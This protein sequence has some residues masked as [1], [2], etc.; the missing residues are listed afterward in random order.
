MPPFQRVDAIIPPMLTLETFPWPPR[1]EP[2]KTSEIF[3]DDWA[4]SADRSARHSGKAAQTTNTSEVS[5]EQAIAAAARELVQ[6]R[7]N[8]LNPS[9]ASVGTIHESP[10]P[11]RTLTNFYNQRP[12]WLDNAH[13]KLDAAVFAAYGWPVDLSDDEILA[14]LLALNL[15]RAAAQ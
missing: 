2:S 1:K 3:A 9:G 4:R 14:R 11:K 12:T 10:L 15:E 6:L 8:W 13:R 5:L 7:D